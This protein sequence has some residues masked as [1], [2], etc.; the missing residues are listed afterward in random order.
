MKNTHDQYTAEEKHRIK[1]LRAIRSASAVVLAVGGAL[2]L[3]GVLSLPPLGVLDAWPLDD[4]A[5]A[6]LLFMSF[7]AGW[8]PGYETWFGDP[9][10]YVDEPEVNDG[11]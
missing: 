4:A 5:G 6:A 9:L 7:W 8:K 3:S 11:E 2:F 1:R 10:V